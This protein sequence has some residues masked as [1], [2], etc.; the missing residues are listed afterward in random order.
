MKKSVIAAVI[1]IAAVLAVGATI[2]VTAISANLN[3]GTSSDS[4][5]ENVSG[6]SVSYDKTEKETIREELK[7]HYNKRL[8][9]IA[10]ELK[11]KGQ[12]KGIMFDAE[13]QIDYEKANEAAN[14]LKKYN[15]LDKDFTFIRVDS[16]DGNT[17]NINAGRQAMV[18]CMRAAC[19]LLNNSGIITAREEVVLEMYLESGYY[20]L[21]EYGGQEDLMK[22]IEKLV[23][24]PF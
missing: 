12:E 13:I 17:E 18:D 7:A 14:V 11:A 6:Q 21:K 19:E 8:D 24:L 22:Q 16:I 15:K 4:M 10:A 2:S 9:E 3:K 1:S 5:N 20:A 23:D